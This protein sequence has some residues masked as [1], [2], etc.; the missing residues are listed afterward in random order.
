MN[1]DLVFTK[2]FDINATPS[3]VWEALTNPAHIKKYLFGTDTITDWIAGRPIIFKGTWEGNEYRD[4]GT[5]L[6]IE[7]EKKLSYTYWSSM[8]G[9]ADIP[10]NYSTLTFE[11]VPQGGGTRILFT[12]RGFES[13]AG[14]EHSEQNWAAVMGGLKTLA[15]SL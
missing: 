6:E 10:E 2:S 15:E 12:Q 1:N 3:K 13:Q 4:G 9:T 7:K 11:L 14:M 8:S 5:I